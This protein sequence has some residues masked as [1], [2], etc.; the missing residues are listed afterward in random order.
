MLTHLRLFLAALLPCKAERR[1][2]GLYQFLLYLCVGLVQPVCPAASLLTDEVDLH[3]VQEQSLLACTYRLL[4]TTETLSITAELEGHPLLVTARQVYPGEDAVTAVLFLV[5]TSDPGR[6]PVIDKN[7]EQI[8]HLLD[9]AGPRH[10]LG[11]ASFDKDLVVSVPVGAPYTEIAAAA[12]RLRALGLTTELYRSTMQAMEL[13]ARTNADRK[14]IFLF[15][16][17]QA[18]DKAYFH[19]DVVTAARE[20][21]II[22]N[23]FGFPRSRALSVSL[24]TLRRLSEETGGSFVEAD[25]N[26]DLP[27]AYMNSPYDNIDR[28]GR[29]VVDL[30]VD[31]VSGNGLSVQIRFAAIAGAYSIAVPVSVPAQPEQTEP[32]LPPASAIQPVQY[33]AAVTPPAPPAAAGVD[34]WLWYGVPLALMVLIILVLIT[35]AML[36]RKPAPP[37]PLENTRHEQVRP[38]AYLI[39]QNE[40]ATRYSINAPVWRIGRSL[41]NELTINDSSISRRH[42]ELQ[43]SGNGDFYIFDRGSTNGVYVNNKKIS[44]HRLQEGDIIEIGD[45]FLRFTAHPLDF[46][47]KESTAML[48]TKAPW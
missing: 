38:L 48:K 24:Q 1:Q 46:H 6:Q 27:D 31:G 20:N 42:A 12:E 44:K 40:K 25:I 15:S 39:T 5:D 36:W 47:M 11:L 9:K 16:D 10:S 33:T 3:C 41:D 18:E 17:G 35:L 43:R 13:L 4:Q 8:K 26:F 45:V 28:G 30:T 29:F 21:G 14:A 19:H 32:D 34:A 23:T 22:I 2:G 7:V 37:P